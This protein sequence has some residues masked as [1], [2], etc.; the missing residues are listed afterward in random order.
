MALKILHADDHTL[1]REG[2]KFFLKLLDKDVVVVEASNFQALTDQ[3]TLEAPIDLLLLDLGM[4]G[5]GELEGFF[6][7]RRQHPDLW[8][9]VLSGGNNPRVIRSILDGGA[10]GYIPKLASS[11]ELMRA[12]RAVVGGEVY[13]PN[14]LFAAQS[15]DNRGHA[16]SGHITSRQ[17]DILALLADGMPNK[18]I[19]EALGIT[20]GTVKQHLK[21]FY[22]RLK[23]QNRTQAI[24]VARSMNLIEK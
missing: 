9:V 20:E 4:A 16:D 10:R 8:V 6:N 21:I 1:F 11:E 15:E 19:A 13:T 2:M 23:V 17:H 7:V 22:R 12:L 5:M 18:L 14:F 24:R 3:L